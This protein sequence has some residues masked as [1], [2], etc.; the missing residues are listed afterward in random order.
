MRQFIFF[1][2]SSHVGPQTRGTKSVLGQPPIHNGQDSATATTAKGQLTQLAV[3]IT[4]SALQRR[5]IQGLMTMRW[6]SWK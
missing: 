5:F 1:D 3:N 6:E 4:K 2:V